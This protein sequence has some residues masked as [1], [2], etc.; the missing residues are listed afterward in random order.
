MCD[1]SHGQENVPEQLSILCTAHKHAASNKE[2][3]VTKCG[4]CAK[5]L[6]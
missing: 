6:L 4:V 3:G 2:H 1:G 5:A